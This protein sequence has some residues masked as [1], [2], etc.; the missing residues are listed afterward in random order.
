[1]N[2]LKIALKEPV[3]EIFTGKY[4]FFVM[5]LFVA[6]N[7]CIVPIF[8]FAQLSTI[9]TQTVNPSASFSDMTDR[10]FAIAQDAS[11]VYIAGTDRSG[12]VQWR[13]EK[14]DKATGAFIAGFG[15]GGVIQE[16][17]SGTDDVIYGAA[18]DAS[19][20]FLVG[21]SY[22]VTSQQW[23]IEKRD[24]T[25][26][27]LIAGFGTGGIITE[28]VSAIE[29]NARAIT[30]DGSGIYVVGYD[31]TPGNFQWR[32]EKRDLTTGALMAGFGTGGVVTYH[33]S[34]Y[35]DKAFAITVD[36]SGIYIAGYTD[37]NTGVT[38]QD[39]EWLMEKR[40]AS[41][42]ALIWRQV[43]NYGVSDVFT[44][45]RDVAYSVKVNSSGV[46]V[47]GYDDYTTNSYHIQKLDLNTGALIAAFGT[48]GD[49]TTFATTYTATNPEQGFEVC[50][51]AIDGNGIYITGQK[52]GG[53][54]RTEQRDLTTGALICF[55]ESDPS[56]G[57]DRAAAITLD[58]T[59]LYVAGHDRV[60][61]NNQWRI[62]KY[63]GTSP[64][65]TVPVE[66]LYFTARCSN[67]HPSM[68]LNWATASETNN[69]Y[70]TVERSSLSFG[71][72][73]GEVGTVQGAGNSSTIRNYEFA[74]AIPPSL[75]ERGGGEVYYRL[76]QTDFDGEYEYF[77]PIS[78]NCSAE[79]QI[80]VF[81]SISNSGYF[82]VVGKEIAEEITV[83]NLLG[84]KSY[85]AKNES[86]PFVIDLTAQSAGVYII[87]VNTA[88]E[89]M[90][91]KLIIQK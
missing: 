54:W 11:G 25:T 38:L 86:L 10:A 4:K 76:K 56:A 78:V 30:V 68:T 60:P 72:G 15:T 28:D 46:Y 20:L 87:R 36:A 14:R 32:I 45:Y 58:G 75:V 49:V 85:S 12:G 91:Q 90:N 22:N 71:E 79:Q 70:F 27:A 55:I 34:A 50:A 80:M 26:G 62:E 29:D 84:E 5:I 9:W 83:Y 61:G 52:N 59:G 82:T 81:P 33:P 48:A 73:W 31:G 7:L 53:Q 35:S 89:V 43:Y 65:G 23:R 1:M 18:T 2:S 8:S 3:M 41:T 6:I 44:P 13:I 67:P 17:P 19:G 88:G 42:G 40:D 64:C 63:Q 16:N 51:L 39:M 47:A 66:L 37:I 74:D 21:H 24:L 77:G 69:H 57:E